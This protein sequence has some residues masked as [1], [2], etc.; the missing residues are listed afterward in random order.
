M[1][2]I[3]IPLSEIVEKK[4]LPYTIM[5]LRAMIKS[6]FLKAVNIGLGQKKPRW[7]ISNVEIL[8]FMENL[9]KKA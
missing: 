2:E 7:A 9:K 6:G 5:N 4:L 8:N 3:L 1:T